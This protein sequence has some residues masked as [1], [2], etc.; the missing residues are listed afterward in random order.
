MNLFAAANGNVSM[1]VG[2]VYGALHIASVL[3][4]GVGALVLL[5]GVVVALSILL[6]AELCR[7]R[8]DDPSAQHHQLRR[9]LG[10]YLLLGLEFL[11][12]ADIIETITA[13][14]WEVVGVLAVIVAIR[15][16]ISVPESCINAIVL[17]SVLCCECVVLSLSHPAIDRHT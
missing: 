4:G 10:L 17:S 13:P 8:G 12:A 3:V 15:T 6:K 2:G 14:D 16:V 9:A 11:V 1:I 7:L 5:W